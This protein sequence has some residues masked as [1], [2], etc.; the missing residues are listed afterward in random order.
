MSVDVLIVRICTVL[1]TGKLQQERVVV[2]SMATV[3]TKTR[4]NV[5]LYCVECIVYMDVSGVD[6]ASVD[7]AALGLSG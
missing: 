6:K 1:V 3:A 7:P 2:V 4:H 5:T